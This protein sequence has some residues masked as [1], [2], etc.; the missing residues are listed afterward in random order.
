MA[1]NTIPY[2]LETVVRIKKTGQFAI[3]KDVVF[4]KDGKSFLYYRG[5]IEGKP[6]GLYAIFHE[7]IEL[8]VLPKE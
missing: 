1:H 3:I 6:E 8:E 7:D 2:P 4:L 5:I